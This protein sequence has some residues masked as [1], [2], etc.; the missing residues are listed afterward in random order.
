MLRFCSPVSNP[1]SKPFLCVYRDGWFMMGVMFYAST[2]NLDQAL[3]SW[4]MILSDSQS[5]RK[6]DSLS[7]IAYSVTLRRVMSPSC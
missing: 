6:I 2:A 1:L 4:I 7:A 5:E 3:E